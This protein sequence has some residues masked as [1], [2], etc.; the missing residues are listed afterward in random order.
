MADGRNPNEL[1]LSRQPCSAG[2]PAD[3]LVVIDPPL[4]AVR[5]LSQGGRAYFKEQGCAVAVLLY[6][7]NR[8]IAREVALKALPGLSRT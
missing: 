5:A 2:E 4:Q 7:R 3:M 6:Q 8:D 1:M